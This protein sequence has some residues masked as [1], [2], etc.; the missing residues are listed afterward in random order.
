MICS[1]PWATV[2]DVAQLKTGDVVQ[3]EKHSALIINNQNGLHILDGGQL[4]LLDPNSPPL[5]EKILIVAA[6]IYRASV[7]VRLRQF[8]AFG[9]V[10][11][12]YRHDPCSQ[13]MREFLVRDLSAQ[14]L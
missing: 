7:G 14:P 9:G 3:W 12:H 6:R 13:F 10:T 11:A 4:I 2:N 5:T 1:A 8:P